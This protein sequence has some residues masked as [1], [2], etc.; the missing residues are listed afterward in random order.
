[1]RSCASI[2]NRLNHPCRGL[3]HGSFMKNYDSMKIKTIL[4]TALTAFAFLPTA[5]QPALQLRADNI[6]AVIAAMTL[7]EKAN[8]VVGDG[9]GGF[10]AR[11]V[12]GSSVRQRLF[13][14]LVSLLWCS[15]TALR[16][17]ASMSTDRLITINTML[18]ISLL[19]R[20][21]PAL[22]IRHSSKMSLKLWDKK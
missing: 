13:H 1:M 16:D 7:E 17:C 20:L 19:A 11:P 8:L 5:A 15:A 22:G 21:W 14:V 6:D 2:I 18:L 4:F 10:S 9:M 3:L 12:I